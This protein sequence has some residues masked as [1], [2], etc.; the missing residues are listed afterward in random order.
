VAK[1]D[2]LLWPDVTLARFP[3]GTLQAMA[4]LK[5]KDESRAGFIRVAV[6]R[7]ITRRERAKAKDKGR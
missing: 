5:N 3:I 7:E 2:K 6:E 1:G 4:A